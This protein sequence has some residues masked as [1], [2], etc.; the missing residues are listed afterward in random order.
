MSRRSRPLAVAFVLFGSLS[1][2][3]LITEM[4]GHSSLG[5]G[6]LPPGR[7][8]RVTSGQALVRLSSGAQTVLLDRGLAGLGAVRGVDLGG[9]WH[10]VSL[11]P[12]QSVAAA[13]P[14]L[15]SLPGVTAADPSRVY[16]ASRMPNDP[17]I[18]SQYALQ[19]V[20]AFA[21]W[22]YETG[23]STRVTIAVIDTGIQGTHPDLSA[24]LANTTS[25]AFNP[26]TGAMSANEPPTPA[27]NH[28][29]RVAGVA[30]ASTD[31]TTLIAG[32]S[33]G[34]QLLS[35]KVFLDGDCPS[36]TCGDAACLTND[37]G[38]IAAI[39]HAASLAD[40]AA[41]GKLIINISLGGSEAC[42]VA[43]QTAI[44]NAV[45]AGA[46]IVAA[47]G[48][49]GAGINSPGNCA[50]L[51]P[52][53]ATDS[54]NGIA[55][56]SSRGAELAANGLVA[57]GVAVLTTD[58]SGNTASAT[59]TSFSAPMVS[60]LAA[61]IR[62]YRPAYTPAQVSALIRGGADSLGV[63]GGMGGAGRMNAY[64]SLRLTVNGTL[65]G[66][67]GQEKAIAFPNPFRLSNSGMVAFA[68]PP[69][70]QGATMKIKIYTLDGQPVRELSGLSWDGKNANGNLVASGTYVFVVS[71]SAGTGRGR[72]SVLR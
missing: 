43:V 42:P 66:F 39:N 59:G 34:A 3:A 18:A 65:A 8:M 25:K 71:S 19:Q 61:L 69:S 38:L 45:T 6:V 4:I 32:M 22:E 54:N 36:V 15:R 51:I 53:G 33:W 37:A 30:A 11:A 72:L 14:A 17:Q 48:N 44:T 23:T 56:F 10:L 47:A 29:T 13:L 60:G 63:S 28:A 20:S 64:R 62:S 68:I 50:G 2:Q 24:K 12:G 1:A 58:L 40:T 55:A 41:V 9:G 26:N 16:A 27:C 5:A 46:V 7:T 49:D 21:A 67:D 35:L 31:N 52:V 57:P 70:L